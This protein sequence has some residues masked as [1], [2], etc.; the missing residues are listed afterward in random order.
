MEINDS[1]SIFNFYLSLC[2]SLHG[3][4]RGITVTDSGQ[5]LHVL[6]SG[7]LNVLIVCH[8]SVMVASSSKGEN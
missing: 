2:L 6:L 8:T 7:V 1:M 4:Q 5:C 3:N